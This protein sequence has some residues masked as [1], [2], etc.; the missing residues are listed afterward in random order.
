[1]IP[2]AINTSARFCIFLPLIERN[3]SVKQLIG[4]LTETNSMELLCRF[5]QAINVKLRCE[6]NWLVVSEVSLITSSNIV[7]EVS[8]IRQQGFEVIE[9]GA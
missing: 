6:T 7:S 3:S 1:M 8:L 9:S 5:H 4:S 2:I